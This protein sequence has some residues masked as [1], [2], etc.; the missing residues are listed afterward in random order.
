MSKRPKL[1][2]SRLRD[3]GWS[4]WDPIGLN[5][6]GDDWESVTFADEY[7][8]YLIKVAGMLKN[9]ESAEKAASYLVHSETVN[10]GLSFRPEMK[11]RAR[12]VVQAI[13][14]DKELWRFPTT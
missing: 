13:Q 11:S 4:L 6:F 12:I 14:N 9:G 2:L 7:D 3:I 1:R 10:M 8:S 5:D